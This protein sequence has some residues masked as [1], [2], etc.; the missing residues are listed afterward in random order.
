MADFNG[1]DND[2]NLV[3]ND[4]ED[5]VIQG[6]DGNDSL[7]GL[8]GND[9]LIGGFGN[10]T[11]DGGFGNDTL[12]GGNGDDIY[13]I[14]R[15]LSGVNT[16][17]DVAGNDTLEIFDTEGTAFQVSLEAP[18]V[19]LIGIE[20]DGANVLV[21]IV[22]DGIADDL[23]VEDFFASANS[24]T[25]GAGFIETFGVT[26]GRDVQ[27]FLAVNVPPENQPPVVGIGNFEIDEF[28]ANGTQ[29]G[30]LDIS[31]PDG[32]D[33][34][35]S[36]SEASQVRL[37]NTFTGGE[38]EDPDV[39]G[40]GDAPFAIDN[41]GVITVNDT[42]DLGP[43]FEVVSFGNFFAFTRTVP[44]FDLT[45][46]V[47]DG[48]ATTE[49]ASSIDVNL[50]RPAFGFGD[51][52]VTTF[53]RNSFG[54][55]VVGEFT[56]IEST[57]ENNPLNIQARTAPAIQENGEPSD[58]L[59]NY[60]AIGTEID[61]NTVAIYAGEENPVFVDGEAVTDFGVAGIEVGDGGRI[62]N[63]GNGFF[64][65]SLGG[66]AQERIVVQ[67]FENRIDPRFFLS[68][69][70]NGNITGVMGNK[71][72]DPSNDIVDSN[73]DVI[74]EATFEQINGEFA[75]AFRI[76]DGAN[77]LLL[78]DGEDIENINNPDF[79][80]EEVTLA[81][82][83]AELGTEAFNE[84]VAQVEEAGVPEGFL[85]TSAIIDFATT[86]DDTFIGSA[87]NVAGGNATP[88]VDN[89]VFTIEEDL[90]DGEVVGTVSI[91]DGDDGLE[92][93][94]VSISA[95]N[96][97]IDGDGEAPFAID[98]QGQIT[99]NDSGDLDAFG[100]TLSVTATDPLGATATGSVTIAFNPPDVDQ[101]PSVAA[102]V[103]EI[104]ENSVEGTIVG[105]AIAVDAEGDDFTFGLDGELDP[106]GNGTDAFTIAPENGLITVA[107]PGD[108]DFETTPSFGFDITATQTNDDTI[109]G[110]STVTVNLIDND[111]ETAT[112]TFNL[113][114]DENG[115]ANGSVDGLNI[116]N[117]LFGL[118]AQTMDTSQA[119]DEVGQQNIFDN[120]QEGLDIDNPALDVDRSGVANGSVDGLNILRVLANLGPEQ[121]DISQTDLGQQNVFDNVQA[122]DIPGDDILVEPIQPEDGIPNH[123]VEANLTSPVEAGSEVEINLSYRTEDPEAANAEF[124]SFSVAVD[125]SVLQ[126]EDTNPDL[127]GIQLPEGTFVDRFEFGSLLSNGIPSAFEDTNNLDND[128]N[129]DVLISFAYSRGFDEDWPFGADEIPEGETSV[130]LG[131]L[132]L[133]LADSFDPATDTTTANIILR[134][135]DSS[136]Q[137]N[138][139]EN[140]DELVIS[141]EQG[142]NES[143]VATDDS[144]QTDEDTVLNVDAANG[145]LTNDSD[146]DGD[147][148]TVSAVNGEE[149]N[150]GTTFELDSGTLLTLNADGSYEY[151]PNGAFEDLND[152]DTATDTFTYTVA[153]G[154]GGTNTAEITVTIDGITDGFDEPVLSAVD[155]LVFGTSNND[156]L[157]A[158][159]QNDPYT[160]NNQITFTGAGEDLVDG[161]I[162]GDGS[163]RNYGGSNADELFAGNNDRLFGE[164][165]NDTLDASQGTGNNR[166][167]GGDDN[168]DLIAGN[169]D[170]LTGGNGDD[171]LFVRQGGNN[172]LI[173]NSGADQFWIA[174]DEIPNSPNIITD[175]TSGE[176]A[177]GFGGFPDL[178][179]SDLS[180]SQE[181]SNTLIGLDAND[182][183]AELQ[184]VQANTLTEND[185]VFAAQSPQ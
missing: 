77:S 95:G 134:D 94:E 131:K 53:D 23:I 96:E 19:G 87:L 101:P 149:A 24:N 171:R 130:D 33:L 71:D 18:T 109:I 78:R 88:E 45:V 7:V 10:D 14:S 56:L 60:T 129:T 100:F 51:P 82:L 13:Q 178:S 86:G 161:S 2:N 154:N 72:G 184:G 103:N 141:A 5:D 169:D 62:V 163:N 122:L 147:N 27:D 111:D 172:L 156:T 99:I 35:V 39:D 40:D 117:F 128:P 52:H 108:L 143:P 85:R 112:P 168:D 142:I 162:G 157:N 43:L 16:I 11:L 144:N 92:N 89:A 44:S 26:S 21:D 121:M 36:L 54:F 126:L 155:D 41:E 102:N 22:A 124:L 34:T 65:I 174:T 107:D 173:G 68:E 119:P 105:Q 4:N 153:D 159:D 25:P 20:R 177:I 148:L 181:G 91:Q 140:L 28:A 74:Q 48:E 97:D 67:V 3:G 75:E 115:V 132:R 180:L 145:V 114:V 42:D 6:F 116:L 57:D 30:Q 125:S 139:E 61:G 81:S 152:G 46:E 136:F 98:G 138:P 80:A 64:N 179:F 84:I 50:G 135:P 66:E 182:P 127:S 167:Y 15:D 158:A 37:I 123:V 150:V 76:T 83:E 17:N 133:P 59:S 151:D 73:G 49:G 118:G 29:F 175:F 63:L 146:P 113:D 12:N 55:Q 166:L 104:R 90:A 69:E 31:D 183:I 32:D 8:G 38:T 79:P 120:I 58:R 110:T 9:R 164:G 185:F 47:S 93:L 176:D 170:L 165:G 160:G 137:A 70:R 1:D 106:N